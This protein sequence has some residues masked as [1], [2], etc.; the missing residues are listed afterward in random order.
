MSFKLTHQNIQPKN[1]KHYG[2]LIK[3]THQSHPIKKTIKYSGMS[4][5]LAN[6][7]NPIGTYQTFWDEFQIHTSNAS[8]QKTSN[9][10]PWVSNLNTKASNQKISNFLTWVSNLNTKAS[11]QKTS[12][13]LTWVSNLNTKAIQSKNIK[14]SDMS[15][16]LKH[17]GNP[18]KKHQIFCHEFQT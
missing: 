2:M 18:I 5:K 7:K 8:N 4:F 1:I 16:K 12:N 15:F 3:L 17:Q 6:K 11:N 14:F 10:L 13:F 9:F